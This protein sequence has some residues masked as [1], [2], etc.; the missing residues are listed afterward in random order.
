MLG[1]KKDL[2]YYLNL[3]YPF[4]VIEDKA[5]GGYTISFPDLPGCVTC[6]DKKEDIVP[7]A[8]DAKRCWLAAAL[9]MGQDVPIP[10]AL[11]SIRKPQ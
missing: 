3:V 10:D 4:L 1:K 9:E 7:M 6:V 2:E 11:L 5:E 8:E